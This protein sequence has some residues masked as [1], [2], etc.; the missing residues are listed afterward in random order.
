M[1]MK[2]GKTEEPKHDEA[3]PNKPEE[4]HT[5]QPAN[6]LLVKK[7]IQRLLPLGTE[8]ENSAVTPA[9][10]T[11]GTEGTPAVNTGSETH[12]ETPSTGTTEQPLL[13]KL[14]LKHL[15]SYYWY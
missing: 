13:V 11:I 5:E 15:Q 9:N 2:N 3:Q 7:L 10:P 8:G 6:L 12:T 4:T 14:I 1:H